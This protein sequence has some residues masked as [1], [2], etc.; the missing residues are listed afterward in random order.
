MALLAA[1]AIGMM[2]PS[3]P[4][5]IQKPVFVEPAPIEP[6]VVRTIP[7]VRP[8]PAEAL[9]APPKP[10]TAAAPPPHGR[11]AEPAARKKPPQRDIC[12]GKGKR[13]TNNK[14]SWRCNR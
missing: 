3:R 10:V 2:K 7:I 13:Y 4:P 14:R 1:F 9:S 12:R 6:T 5:L 8:P 11:E